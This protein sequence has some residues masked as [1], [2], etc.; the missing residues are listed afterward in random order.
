MINYI[1]K[2]I[3]FYIIIQYKYR[4]FFKKTV[5]WIFMHI[6]ANFSNNGLYWLDIECP[7]EVNSQYRVDFTQIFFNYSESRVKF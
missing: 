1:I 7:F 2:N 3:A 5:K 6:I 4:L